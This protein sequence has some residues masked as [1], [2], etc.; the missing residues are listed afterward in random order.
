MAIIYTYPRVI[1]P[2]GTELIVVSETKNKNATRIMA[3]QDIWDHFDC[4]HC[5]F[6]TT[7]ISKLV[8]SL[9]D[10]I[11]ATGCDYTVNLISSDGSISIT[12]NA[13]TDTIDFTS[14]SGGCPVSYVVKPVIC[15]EEGDCKIEDI[16]GNWFFTC[17]AA[18]GAL[19]P[20]YINNFKI[21]G[22]TPA[23]PSGGESDC[24]WIEEVSYAATATTCEECC[25]EPEGVYSYTRCDCP[26]D[27]WPAWSSGGS[28]IPT[29][30]FFNP[31]GQ[32]WELCDTIQVQLSTGDFW[33]YQKG[34]EVCDPEDTWVVSDDCTDCGN[35][36]ICACE[37]TTWTFKKCDTVSTYVTF[38][39][40]PADTIGSVRS[41]CCTG[42]ESTYE[43]WE[44]MGSIGQPVG[45]SLPCVQLSDWENCE[46]CKNKCVFEYQACDGNT[47]GLPN[48]IYYNIGSTAE[49]ECDLI[50]QPSNPVFTD[51]VDTWCYTLVGETCEDA[52]AGITF[53]IEAFCDDEEY[54]PPA[55]DEVYTF[56]R[57]DGSASI[58]TALSNITTSWPI[59]DYITAEECTFATLALAPGAENGWVVT[60]GGLDSG[61]SVTITAA[62]QLVAEEPCCDCCLYPCNYT[63]TVPCEG[64]PEEAPEQVTVEIP[65]V[66]CTSGLPSNAVRIEYAPGLF[67]CYLTPVKECIPVTHTAE[68]FGDDC[69]LCTEYYRYWACTSEEPVYFYTDN[70]LDEF[71]SALTL[72]TVLSIGSVDSCEPEP[73]CFE[74][75][76][77]PT[78]DS[79]P[80]TA[81]GDQGCDMAYIAT[82]DCDCC[83]NVNVAKYQAC[84]ESGDACNTFGPYYI[85]TCDQW[86]IPISLGGGPEYIQFEVTPEQF[87][88]FEKVDNE[89]CLPA[90]GFPP[91]VDN[92]GAGFEDCNCEG[93][94]F[95]Q[96]RECGAEEWTD[97][98]TDLSGYNT[99]NSWSN[100]DTEEPV[101]YEIQE[102]GIGGPIIDPV[103]L[104]VTQYSA[105][106]EPT[107]PCDCCVYQ[108]V[109]SY[110]K[111][112]LSTLADC[113]SMPT[114]INLD[115]SAVPVLDFVLVTDTVN[116]WTCCYEKEEEQP[117]A[118]PTANHTFVDVEGACSDGDIPPECEA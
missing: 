63:Y 37:E 99:G 47:T 69:T 6:C 107:T 59:D 75:E 80:L 50:N 34:D 39:V 91:I 28:L 113:A 79:E 44:Y 109:Y 35:P 110:V 12:G 90:A 108:N 62:P 97:T 81:I 78:Y 60:A 87:C 88:C 46:C 111:C 104:F 53:V 89:E 51:G 103:S 7:S 106:P 102:G 21:G 24:W 55:S 16:V 115:M 25:C 77:F 73:C 58:I 32:P 8:P 82:K 27:S 83:E 95:F 9:G 41:Y 112:E 40:E 93:E 114:K 86:G 31:S 13:L 94:I 117:C 23:H 29:E 85:N 96:Y 30:V 92:G 43:C 38:D 116:G 33:C 71:V 14:A 61:T 70:I 17:D 76:E 19:A 4:S 2:D 22:I 54:C 10:S 56:T 67:W 57:C 66:E 11:S 3:V 84:A 26:G 36:E 45:G 48:T 98:S 100:G 15:I 74:I 18:L 1:N 64:K 52:T 68:S 20:G 42:D 118:A 105:G 101:C 65:E 5:D 72:P 49:C